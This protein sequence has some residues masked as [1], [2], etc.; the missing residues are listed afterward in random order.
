MAKCCICG[1]SEDA[2]RCVCSECAKTIQPMSCKG[3]HHEGTDSLEEHNGYCMRCIRNRYP[4]DLYEP[5][6]EVLNET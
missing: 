6:R 1:K 2:M 4:R 3:C 5:K